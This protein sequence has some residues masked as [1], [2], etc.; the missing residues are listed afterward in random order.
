[1]ETERPPWERQ[2]GESSRAYRYFEVYRDLGAERSLEK[3]RQTFAQRSVRI[4]VR[5]L[6]I[7]SSKHRWVERALAWDDYQAR[8]LAEQRTREYQ[9]RQARLAAY[10][11]YLQEKAMQ[12]AQRVPLE[13]L[14]PQDVLRWLEYGV[15]L[16]QA[17]SPAPPAAESDDYWQN[18]VVWRLVDALEERLP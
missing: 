15:Q 16:E 2:P 10:G 5:R 1:M 4:S 12:A 7:L 17:H 6:A 13:K 11:R 18:P 3:V 8:L 14:T 9:E